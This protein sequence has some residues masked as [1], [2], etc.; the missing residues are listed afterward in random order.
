MEV[1]QP[2]GEGDTRG[3]RETRKQSLVKQSIT[4][5]KQGALGRETRKAI[6]AEKLGL[7]LDTR[8]A[9]TAENAH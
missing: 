3:R 2:S 6:I 4:A 9:S 5:Y 1:D 8:K 7:G